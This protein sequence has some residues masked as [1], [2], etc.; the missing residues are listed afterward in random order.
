MPERERSSASTA[1][2]LRREV[3]ATAATSHSIAATWLFARRLAETDDGRLFELRFSS[4]A[5]PAV[6]WP[7][8]PRASGARPA[9]VEERLVCFVDASMWTASSHEY[10]VA[11]GTGGPAAARDRRLTGGDAGRTA[12]SWGRGRVAPLAAE[13]PQ[14][15][16]EAEQDECGENGERQR[17]TGER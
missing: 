5:K 12:R 9:T 10:A 8:E 1:D 6:P 11:R 15:E 16:P 4:E 14:Q 7:P 3:A 13:P 2:A 17:G